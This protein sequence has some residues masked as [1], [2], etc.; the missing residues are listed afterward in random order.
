[1][2]YDSDDEESSVSDEDSWHSYDTDNEHES[3]SDLHSKLLE[4]VKQ[5]VKVVST[6][7]KQIAAFDDQKGGFEHWYNDKFKMALKEMRHRVRQEKNLDAAYELKKMAEAYFEWKE[8]EK[9]FDYINR[10]SLFVN[11]LLYL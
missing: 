10:V 11:A 9:A 5:S 4:Q 2:L 7:D 1:M 8:T 3:L 6:L